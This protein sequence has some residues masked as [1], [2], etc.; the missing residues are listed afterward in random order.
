MPKII[1]EIAIKRKKNERSDTR[2]P[3]DLAPLPRKIGRRRLQKGIRVRYIDPAQYATGVER[4]FFYDPGFTPLG[5]TPP[6]QELRGTFC[7][8]PPFADTDSFLSSF[9]SYYLDGDRDTWAELYREAK[10]DET[11]QFFAV[12]VQNPYEE[13]KGY[14]VSE[15][16]NASNGYSLKYNDGGWEQLWRNFNTATFKVTRLPVYADDAVTFVL[17]HSSD[18]FLSPSARF[19]EGRASSWQPIPFP[20]LSGPFYRRVRFYLLNHF[21]RTIPR[22]VAINNS[23]YQDWWARPTRPT[24]GG[25]WP[26]HQEL[27][28]YL[29]EFFYEIFTGVGEARTTAIDVQAWANGPGGFAG[30]PNDYLVDEGFPNTYSGS[31]LVFDGGPQSNKTWMDF[32]VVRWFTWYRPEGLLSAIIN[33]KGGEDHGWYYVWRAEATNVSNPY[34]SPAFPTIAAFGGADRGAQV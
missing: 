32:P 19:W 28:N 7:P 6:G 17:D 9:H 18:V 10:A 8:W 2:R 12:G 24:A 29:R 16:E 25:N 26:A 20:P 33:K 3:L 31:G 5:Y 4:P 14:P 22:S 21:L 34:G 23:L 1:T 27:P 11:P 30:D 15:A 13:G